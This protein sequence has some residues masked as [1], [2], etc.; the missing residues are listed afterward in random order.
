MLVTYLGALGLLFSEGDWMLRDNASPTLNTLKIAILIQV[1]QPLFCGGI[2]FN[3]THG[4]FEGHYNEAAK[5][6]SESLNL[7]S[8]N[9]YISI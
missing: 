4:C 7:P 5:K 3:G 1:V 2:Y 8:P 9:I 6:E